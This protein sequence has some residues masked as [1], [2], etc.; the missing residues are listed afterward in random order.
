MCIAH[1]QMVFVFGPIFV[2][3]SDS[4]AINTCTDLAILAFIAETGAHIREV[5]GCYTPTVWRNV[6][7]VSPKQTILSVPIVRFKHYANWLFPFRLQ[8]N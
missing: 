2:N 1:H 6:Q 5:W 7:K 8:I 4:F 3:N